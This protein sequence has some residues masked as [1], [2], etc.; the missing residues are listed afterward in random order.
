MSASSG[1]DLITDGLVFY[2]DPADPKSYSIGSTCRD[3]TLRNG[4]GALTN[5]TLSADKGFIFSNNSNSKIKF[6]RSFVNKTNSTTYMAVVDLPPPISPF[7]TGGILASTNNTFGGILLLYFNVSP[8][9]YAFE[10]FVGEDNGF[11]IYDII[12]EIDS[13]LWKRRYILAITIDSSK[14]N[15]YIDGILKLTQPNSYNI[16]NQNFINIGYDDTIFNSPIVPG[17][18]IYQT[19]IYDRALTDGEILQNYNSLKTRYRI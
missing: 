15:F 1:P 5:V 18:K 10:I 19:M 12:Y 3:L 2:V 17:Q 11:N 14:V 7:T 9:S 8:S 16:N 4:I 13:N 6:T